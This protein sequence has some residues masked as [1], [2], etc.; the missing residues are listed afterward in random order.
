MLYHQDLGLPCVLNC[1]I[2]FVG[3]LVTVSLMDVILLGVEALLVVVLAVVAV[4]PLAFAT[5][6]VIW[7]IL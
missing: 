3:V 4:V 7:R 2:P 5:I 6:S 1:S